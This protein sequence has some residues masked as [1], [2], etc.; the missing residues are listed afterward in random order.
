MITFLQMKMGTPW[1]LSNFFFLGRGGTFGV[2]FEVS[3]MEEFLDN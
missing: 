3:N 1:E 2:S